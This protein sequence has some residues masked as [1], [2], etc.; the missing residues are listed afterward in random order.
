ML[1]LLSCSCAYSGAA[2][3]ERTSRQLPQ[4]RRMKAAVDAISASVNEDLLLIRAM[5]TTAVHDLWS[6]GHLYI[7]TDHLCCNPC[8]H[9]FLHSVSCSQDSSMQSYV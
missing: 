4:N 5:E 3:V 8:G 6:Y 1:V 7:L 2:A 9:S